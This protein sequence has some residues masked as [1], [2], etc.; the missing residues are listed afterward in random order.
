MAH[1]RSMKSSDLPNADA[2][3]A[4]FHVNHPETPAVALER[5]RLAPEWCFVLDD[6]DGTFAGYAV[7]HPWGGALPP[8]LDGLLGEI[9]SSA[10]RLHIH[11]VVLIEAM[12]GRGLTAPLLRILGAQA[13]R[14]DIRAMTLIAVGRAQGFWT[15]QGFTADHQPEC[16]AFVAKS[17]GPDC[18]PMR[19]PTAAAFT[20]AA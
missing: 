9:P 6:D 18:V 17:Y 10:D 16:V 15:R 11:D 14:A 13:I 3:N 8:A 5:L 12:R 20:A 19:R 1:W 4:A 7:C 2:L